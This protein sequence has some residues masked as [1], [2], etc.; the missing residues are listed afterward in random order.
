M[1]IKL[2]VKGG[3]IL[4]WLP[5]RCG[6]LGVGHDI[7]SCHSHVAQQAKAQNLLQSLVYVALG[8]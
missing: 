8:I 4:Y 3:S 5:S 6:M 7:T 2:P 1:A